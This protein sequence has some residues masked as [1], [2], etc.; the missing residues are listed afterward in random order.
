MAGADAGTIYLNEDSKGL[1]FSIVLNDTLGVDS[2]LWKSNPIKIPTVPLYNEDG[3]QNLR[4]VATFAAHKGATVIVDDAKSDDRFDFS[5]F[6]TFDE[7][8]GYESV[9][10][11]A[12]PLRT[13]GNQTVGVLQLLNA[14]DSQGN[15]TPFSRDTVPLM[16][17]L[18]SQASIAIENR[19]LLD[20]QE[21]LKQQ[22]EQEVDTRTE[23]LKDALSKLSEAHIVMQEMNTI[24]AV[25]NVRTRQYFDEVLDQEWR[26]AKR[27]QYEISLLLLD[28]DYFK[29]VNDTYGHLAGDGC[30]AAVGSLIDSMFNRPSDVVARYGGEEF[31]VVLPYVNEESAFTVAEQVRQKVEECEFE[32]EGHALN[33][34][35]SIGVATL[36]P[37]EDF[38]PRD[39]IGWADQALYEAKASGRNRVIQW[40]RG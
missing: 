12:T 8:L 37:E 21:A 5:G 26:R 6:R 16:E 40:Q 32:A 3:S 29:K 13:I 25:T 30:L 4:N 27:Q 36:L 23:Q 24:D 10:F 19:A 33:V 18:A 14:K 34:T 11:L 28:I 2:A 38:D 22:L 7:M 39:L 1:V 9:S 31:V 15:V 17:A 35:I 20:E